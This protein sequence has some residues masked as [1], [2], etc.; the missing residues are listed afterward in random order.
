MTGRNACGLA[1]PIKLDPINFDD[2]IDGSGTGS[3][4][5]DHLSVIAPSD[6]ALSYKCHYHY[7]IAL[8][9]QY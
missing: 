3:G 5:N 9:E 7:L 2:K 4:S 6:D 8:P 1:L